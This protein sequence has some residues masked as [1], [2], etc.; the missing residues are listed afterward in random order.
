MAS[1]WPLSTLARKASQRTEGRASLRVPQTQ[2]GGRLCAGRAGGWRERGPLPALGPWLA[3][4]GPWRAEHADARPWR[5]EHADAGHVPAPSQPNVWPPAHSRLRS[6]QRAME[7]AP[8]APEPVGRGPAAPERASPEAPAP[9]PLAV[10]VAAVSA[11]DRA[12]GPQPRSR[13]RARKRPGADKLG[14]CEKVS[15]AAEH[16]QPPQTPT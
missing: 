9:E 13:R 6:W 4:A 2:P 7:L 8:V 11:G 16:P 10:A 3:L 1:R 15:P 12:A 14:P 5:A